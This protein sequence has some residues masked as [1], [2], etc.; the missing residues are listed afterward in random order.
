VNEAVDTNLVGTS[1]LER[2]LSPDCAFK[3]TEKRKAAAVEQRRVGILD[4]MDFFLYV[5]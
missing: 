2:S 5:H 1:V 3:V 4:M